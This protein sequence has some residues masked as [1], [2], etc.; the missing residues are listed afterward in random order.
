VLCGAAFAACGCQSRECFLQEGVSTTEL[1]RR[2][3]ELVADNGLA[4]LSFEAEGLAVRIT[5][6]Q[7]AAPHLN[8][9]HVLHATYPPAGDSRQSVP[10]GPAST[11][12]AVE[13]AGITLE[14][15][16]VGVFYRSASP[17]DPPFVNVGDIVRVG[18]TIGL[19]EAMKVY[20]EVPAEAGGRIIAI[21][22]QSG[23]LVQQ[24]QP[25]IILE[26]V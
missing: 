8:P 26:R 4:E 13:P 15:P 3:V 11:A 2:L 1:V 24:G 19:I 18:Q 25:L 22:A 23:V 16:M 12:V 14:S 10:R 5:G 20:S 6:A 9:V 7:A 17:E 21:P